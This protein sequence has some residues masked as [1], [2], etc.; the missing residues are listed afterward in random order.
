MTQ[1]PGEKF[2]SFIQLILG[3]T[4]QLIDLQRLGSVVNGGISDPETK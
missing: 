2:T 3:P 1:E 4:Q